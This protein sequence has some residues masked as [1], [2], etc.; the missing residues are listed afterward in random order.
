MDQTGMENPKFV[1][2]VALMSSFHAL[3]E[4]TVRHGFHL[5]N[6]FSAFTLNL[7]IVLLLYKIKK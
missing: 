6:S 2:G 7:F 3:P 5:N 4:T 1:T